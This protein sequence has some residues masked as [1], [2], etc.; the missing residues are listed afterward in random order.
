MGQL[1]FSIGLHD[2]TND[3]QGSGLASQGFGVCI[4]FFSGWEMRY[5]INFFLFHYSQNPDV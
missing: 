3:D 4:V 5:E 2:L 1:I